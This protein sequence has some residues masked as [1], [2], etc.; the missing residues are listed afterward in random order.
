MTKYLLTYQETERLFFRRIA[1]SDFDAWLP[2]HQ[3]PTSTSYWKGIPEDPLAACR[4]QF[5][6]VFERYEKGQGGMNALILKSNGNLTGMC[7]LLVQTV[8]DLEELEIGYSI[9][10][11]YRKKG[12]ATEAAMKC[13]AYAFEQNFSK[14]LISIIHVDNFLSKKVVINNGMKVDKT[15]TYKNNPVEIFR[16][17][18]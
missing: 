17:I 18:Q 15:T 8:D 11:E 12:F 3:D 5:D 9:L 1:P 13:K 2:F 7:G 14:S 4:E 6:R 16:V 10:P